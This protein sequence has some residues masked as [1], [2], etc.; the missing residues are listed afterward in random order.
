MGVGAQREP[1]N[2][3]HD[4]A[5]ES[6]Q[7]EEEIIRSDVVSWIKGDGGNDAGVQV[8]IRHPNTGEWLFQDPTFETWLKENKSTSILLSAPPGSGKTVLASAVAQHLHDCNLRAVSFYFSFNDPAR[9][10][11]I[12]ALRALALGLLAFQDSV[13]DSVKQLYESDIRNC[14]TEMKD[15]G[16]ATNVLEGLI[17]QISRVHIILDGLDECRDRKVLLPILVTL[18]NFSTY[19]IVKWLLTSRA[20]RDICQEILQHNVHE[21]EA[22][23]ELVNSDIRKFMH[24]SCPDEDW[25]QTIE[26]LMETSKGNFLWANLMLQVLKDSMTSSK[27]DVKKEL[28]KF[29]RD[30]NSL[31]LRTLHRLSKRKLWQQILAQKIFSFLIA[32]VQPLRLSELSHAL[33]ATTRSSTPLPQGFPTPSLIEDLCSNLVRFDRSLPGS[34]EDPLLR[35]THKTVHDFLLQSM[36]SLTDTEEVV[37]GLKTVDA[38][39]KEL[40]EAYLSKKKRSLFLQNIKRMGAPPEVERF[41]TSM[42]SAHRMIGE[43]CVQY[44]SNPRYN[45]PSDP[46]LF[47]DNN[48]HAFLKYAASFWHMHLSQTPPSSDLL[49]R[50]EAFISSPSFWNCVTVQGIVAPYL[51]AIYHEGPES[52]RYWDSNLPMFAKS[53]A[54]IHYGFPLPRWLN[55][56]RAKDFHAFLRQWYRVLNSYP[57]YLN[58]CHM[59]DQWRSRWP[60]MGVWLSDSPACLT[61]H[62]VDATLEDKIVAE[63][64]MRQQNA[65]ANSTSELQNTH[66]D[67]SSAYPIHNDVIR[68]CGRFCSPHCP[69]C[70]TMFPSN[71]HNDTVIIT[72]ELV[73]DHAYSLSDWRVVSYAFNSNFMHNGSIHSTSAVAVQWRFD[74]NEVEDCRDTQPLNSVSMVFDPESDTDSD[75]DSDASSTTASI[76][77][78]SASNSTYKYCLLITR[79]NSEPISYI[80]HSEYEISISKCGFHP[81]EPWV[82]WSPSP[83]MFC[84][85]NTVTGVIETATLPEPSQVDFE[86]TAILYKEFNAS[87]NG[88]C[89]FYL[90]LAASK[91]STGTQYH[92]FISPLEIVHKKGCRLEIHTVGPWSTLSYFL[93]ERT[94]DP[95]VLT[96]WMPDYVYVALPPLS[97]NPKVVRMSL[98]AQDQ[99]NSGISSTFQTLRKPIFFP[100]STLD[101]HPRLRISQTDERDKLVLTLAGQLSNTENDTRS[102][103]TTDDAP[104]FFGKCIRPICDNIPQDPVRMSWSVGHVEDWR[105]WNSTTDAKSELYESTEARIKQL[106]G[107]YTKVDQRF[108]VL[109]SSGL[110]WRTK[111]IISCY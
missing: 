2:P 34:V 50:V 72:P 86:S 85:A 107:S 90:V 49:A 97:C 104:T 21:I 63:I 14:S 81:T 70:L 87:H 47:I 73:P 62:S 59:D 102:S 9:R 58:Q 38:E 109:I 43:A 37:R 77:S 105:D 15:V 48:D 110:D 13:P 88:S 98:Q 103:T 79:E 75:Q 32:A 92:L 11:A 51:Y 36:E 17:K 61:V 60:S 31:Y 41:F 93:A 12:A 19:G 55:T 1:T 100:S 94:Q 3:R 108:P 33:I 89:L 24:D 8:K 16:V 78:S 6:F 39:D 23:V 29:P 56:P 64:Q 7:S 95:F 5:L 20:E 40:D 67:K 10:T 83:H 99:T 101:R 46:L 76:A 28:E 91:S 18:I 96:A 44:L 74:P 68:H 26:D 25:K 22:R 82:Y 45:E 30:L 52:I 27:K 106:R 57:R 69:K 54:M 42:E 84:M 66:G 71:L 35:F 4:M 65:A 80:W 53:G 111:R